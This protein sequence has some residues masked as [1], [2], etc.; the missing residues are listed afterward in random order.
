MPQDSVYGAWPRS[1]EIDIA[2]SRGNDGS[3]YILGNNRI[4]SALHWGASYATD[5]ID[6]TKGSFAAK[7]TKYSDDFHTYG[8][9]WSKKYLFVWLDGRLRVSHTRPLCLLF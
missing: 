9:E 6:K 2:E 3:T 8:L 1:G 4:G 7:R 5:M